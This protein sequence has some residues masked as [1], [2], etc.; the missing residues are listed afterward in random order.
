MNM[1]NRTY[2]II[3]LEMLCSEKK[4]EREINHIC[5][6]IFHLFWLFY[7]FAADPTPEA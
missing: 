1:Y 2:L 4:F 5:I 7:C 3:M 6:F